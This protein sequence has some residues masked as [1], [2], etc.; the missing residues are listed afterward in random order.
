MNFV[1]AP[2]RGLPWLAHFPGALVWAPPSFPLRVALRL[3]PRRI[4]ARLALRRALAHV[5]ARQL[6]RDATTVIAPSLCAR[7]VF[8]EAKRRGLR[9]VLVQDLPCLRR[10]HHDLDRASAAHP[11]S[12]FLKNYRASAAAIVEQEAEWVLAD[13]VR[14]RGAY[15]AQI[16]SAAGAV[17]SPSRPPVVPAPKPRRP[18]RVQLAGIATPRHGIFELLEAQAALD[19][20][21]SV[22]TGEG[23]EPGDLLRRRGISS[24]AGGGT[25]DAVVAP[26]WCEVHLPEVHDAVARGIPV[27]ATAQASGWLGPAVTRVEPGDVGSLVRAL[28]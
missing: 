20:E 27:I 5:A 8:A 28:S 3:A 6:P 23:L 14:V 19:F 9:T 26:A 18:L 7:P 16:V 1:V 13:E 24:G 10:L 25:P 17:V 4:E 12:K 22:R 11:E 21:L 15:A 2:E